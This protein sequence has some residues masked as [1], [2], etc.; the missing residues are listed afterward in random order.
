MAAWCQQNHG[1]IWQNRHIVILFYSFVLV[2]T[3]ADPSIDLQ[4]LTFRMLDTFK[5]LCEIA[6][7]IRVSAH[8]LHQ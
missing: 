4:G 7:K 1:L 6:R 2:D 8:W 3:H 5:Q